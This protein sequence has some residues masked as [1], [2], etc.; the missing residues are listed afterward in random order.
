MPPPQGRTMS[1]NGRSCP[2]LSLDRLGRDGGPVHPPET[3]PL[4]YDCESGP[5]LAFRGPLS[6]SFSISVPWRP[7]RR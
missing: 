2:A 3:K 7:A 4:W 6:I 1:K 5:R